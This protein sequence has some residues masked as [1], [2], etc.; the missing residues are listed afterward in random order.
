MTTLTPMRALRTLRFLAALLV[1]LV[2]GA[3]AL[4]QDFGD[5]PYV[6]TPRNVVETML[7]MAK[8]GPRD[9]VIDL[10]SGDGRM[11][12]TAA[13]K[14]GARGFG[15]DHDARLVQKAK[16]EAAKAG[17][18]DRVNFYA[19]DLY[20]TDVRRATVMTIYLL[21]EVNLMVRGKLFQELRPGTR[22]VSHD[23][24]FGEW[25]PDAQDILDAPDKPVGRDRISKVFFWIVPA[26]V[27]GEWRSRLAIGKDRRD[28]AFSFTQK[29]QEAQGEVESDGARAKMEGVELQGER[30]TFTAVL[31]EGAK[32][33][34]LAFSG[35]VHGEQIDGHVRIEG[36]GA[37]REVPWRA[38]RTGGKTAISTEPDPKL[39]IM[40]QGAQ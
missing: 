5:T 35:R 27:T 20:K 25:K 26:N 9:Y 33:Q 16:A 31:G 13:L 28:V 38:Q 2:T 7:R 8:V 14:Y 40:R 1:A 21:P 11:V 17:V 12:I 30:I 24:D 23:Y 34:K 6:Q 15:V 19:R 22:V 3:P 36:D 4:A 10:G 18:A 37:V 39:A 32:A 29:F